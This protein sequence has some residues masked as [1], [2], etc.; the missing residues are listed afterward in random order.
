M[1]LTSRHRIVDYPLDS[2]ALRD[3]PLGDSPRRTVTVILPPGHDASRAYPMVW[4]LLGFTGHPR[5]IVSND[6]WT[7]GFIDRLDRLHGAGVIGSMVYVVPDAFTKLGGSQYL[8]SSAIGRY[9][10]HLFDELLPF[11]EARHPVT[12]RAILGKSSGGYGAIVHA[13]RRPGT[14]DAVACHSGDM[15]FEY[16][17]QPDFPKARRA[18]E[19][20]GGVRA[21]FEAFS[22]S[23]RK[24]DRPW[25][26][27]LNMLAMAGAYSPNPA[28]TETL[29]IDLPFDLETGALRDDVFARW[30]ACD[31]VRLVERHAEALRAMRLVFVDCGRRDEFSLD[32]GARIFANELAARGIPHEHEEFDDGH[33][34]IAYRYDVSLPK[35]WRAIG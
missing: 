32:V 20:H 31:P 6:P 30:L 7:E 33:M 12:R 24:R 14:F 1:P 5:S 9:E 25:Q 29:G 8:D 26:D 16:C 21:W 18:Y 35:V 2:A 27:A 13:M 23:E 11:V 34:G 15:G 17:Y 10:T 22:A 28:A 19:R 4:L 3:N